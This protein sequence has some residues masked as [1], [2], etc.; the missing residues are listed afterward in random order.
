MLMGIGGDVDYTSIKDAVDAAIA[1]GAS[2]STPWDI[3]IRPG[4]YTESPFTISSGICVSGEMSAVNSN[5]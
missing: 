3:L 4:T 2:A 1:G 5:K